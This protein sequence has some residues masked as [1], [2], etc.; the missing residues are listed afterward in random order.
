LRTPADVGLRKPKKKIPAAS[1]R[2]FEKIIST[3]TKKSLSPG[4]MAD[5]RERNL[6]KLVKKKRSRGKDVVETDEAESQQ[7]N[8]VDIM[9]VLKR[10][11][12][13]KR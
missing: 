4:K 9:E 2:R 5:E 3:R 11:L 6:L 13:S 7:S 10:S 12:A 1:V 8:V